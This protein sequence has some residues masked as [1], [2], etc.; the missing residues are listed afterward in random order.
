MPSYI[1][2]RD[3][4]NLIYPETVTTPNP[5]ITD[6]IPPEVNR[7]IQ[8]DLAK[9]PLR[10]GER[11]YQVVL[12]EN[13]PRPGEQPKVVKVVVRSQNTQKLPQV[14][15][16]YVEYVVNKSN[17]PVVSLNRN[18]SRNNKSNNFINKIR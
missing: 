16:K 5:I 9:N 15:P 11:T 3:P 17:E 10:S 7:V 1:Q 4:V 18:N 6:Q 14:K 8:E 12:N 2:S 13:N